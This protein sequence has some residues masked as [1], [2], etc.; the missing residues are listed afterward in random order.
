[1][2]LR[3]DLLTMGTQRDVEPGLDAHFDVLSFDDKV[4]Y[5]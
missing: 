4:T 5:K 3:T 2:H 1:M